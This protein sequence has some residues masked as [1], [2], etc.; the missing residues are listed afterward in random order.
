MK[1][2]IVHLSALKVFRCSSDDS[3]L[4]TNEHK[5]DLRQIKYVF[6]S[7][8]LGMKRIGFQWYP[9]KGTSSFKEFEVL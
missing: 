6:F 4:S 8:V 7:H 5:F 9:C 3:T 1:M 2:Y